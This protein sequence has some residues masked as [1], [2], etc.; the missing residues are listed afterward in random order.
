MELKMED[1]IID[2]I[3]KTALTFQGGTHLHFAKIVHTLFSKEYLSTLENNKFVLYKKI[4][5][6]YKRIPN[7]DLVR[8]EL[9]DPIA[10]YIDKARYSLKVPQ[11][12][13]PEYESKMA[14]YQENIKKILKLQENCY[15]TTFRNNV[16]KEVLV[17]F[18]DPSF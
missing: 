3:L 7:I 12:K 4:N 8:N 5:D 13:D 17:L 11:D 16:L 10:N 15:N 6:E 2:I 18:Y 1:T 9:I 14:R